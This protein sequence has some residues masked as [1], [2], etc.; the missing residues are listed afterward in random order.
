MVVINK[1]KHRDQKRK[2]FLRR[3]NKGKNTS[4]LAKVKPGEKQFY[5]RRQAKKEAEK[6]IALL[7]EPE[8]EEEAAAID[9][10]CC[11][12][13][14]REG[15]LMLMFVDTVIQVFDDNLHGVGFFLGKDYLVAMRLVLETFSPTTPKGEV[16]IHPD[17]FKDKING[18]PEEFQLVHN[19]KTLFTLR[20]VSII[21][22]PNILADIER[23]V[24]E[25]GSLNIS[26]DT[27][28]F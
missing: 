15:I 9:D 3:S 11:R 6:E 21:K 16:K 26:I 10:R 2:H 14:N 4:N 25:S 24:E 8:N 17:L 19:E 13:F 1:K 5:N 28:I 12:R 22:N 18:L 23:K 20:E 7:L 27:F